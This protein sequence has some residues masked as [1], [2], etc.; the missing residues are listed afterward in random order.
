MTASA[1][2]ISSRFPRLCATATKYLRLHGLRASARAVRQVCSARWQLRKANAPMGVRVRGRVWVHNE[3]RMDLRSKLRFEGTAVRIELVTLPGGKLTIGER[4]YVNY[5]TNISSAK[6]VQIG[7][8]CAIGQYCI[9]MDNDYHQVGNLDRMPE[10]RPVFI[11]DRVWLGARVIVLPG[12]HIGDD[13]VIGANSVVRG[14][15]PAGMIAAGVPARIIRP[16]LDGE[17]R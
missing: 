16:V 14:S 11:G 15:I 2:H 5:G 7:T 9:I 17:L 12:S 13:A 6:S 4:T 10:S 8:G 3:G 1:A